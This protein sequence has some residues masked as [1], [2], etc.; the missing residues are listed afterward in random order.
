MA[1]ETKEALEGLAGT[2]RLYAESE[3]GTKD[4]MQNQMQGCRHLPLAEIITQMKEDCLS[5]W[6]LRFTT[7]TVHA[8]IG[9]IVVLR[10][11]PIEKSE[12]EDSL[13]RLDFWISP[14]LSAGAA[15]GLTSPSRKSNSWHSQ[16]GGDRG[17]FTN[18]T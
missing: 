13:L 2:N 11:C 8:V 17:G 7:A 9:L 6:T 14:A 10:L 1:T 15:I 5:G 18:Y 16:K 4:A 3:G 12:P